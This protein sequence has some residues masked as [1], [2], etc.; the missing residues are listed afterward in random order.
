MRRMFMICVAAIVSAAISAQ[1]NDLYSS[2][3][4]T[5]APTPVT[6][7]QTQT[8]SAAAVSANPT[9][10][11]TVSY[12]TSERDVD[13]YNRRY[14][15]STSTS[16]DENVSAAGKVVHDTVYLK[17]GSYAQGYNDAS[18]EY[19]YALRMMRFHSVS[20]SLLLSPFYWDVVYDPW[21]RYPW[22]GVWVYDPW[23]YPV[24]NP[25]YVGPV[26]VGPAYIAPGVYVRRDTYIPDRRINAGWDRKL[27][28]GAQRDGR[29]GLAASDSR[30]A[31]NTGSGRVS[32]AVTQPIS[33]PAEGTRVE[34]QVSG[35]A[36]PARSNSAYAQRERISSN[37]TAVRSENRKVADSSPRN[38]NATSSRSTNS[39]SNTY[40]HPSS[41]ARSSSAAS[42]S[43]TREVRS[44]G[45]SPVSSFGGAGGSRGGSS[46]GGGSMGGGSSMGGASMGGGARGSSGFSGRR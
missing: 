26:Y 18:E 46:F 37:A 7:V 25:V 6:E 16:S 30:L 33:R 38:L 14:A 5:V 23:Y 32:S 11:E 31:G 12:T 27:A 1:R 17:S 20:V 9:V 21:Y 10:A 34:R 4:K 13:E 39:S 42:S 36:S 2:S 40:S 35:T 22:R 44:I 41:T 45:S 43:Q 24:Y 28:G 15:Y 3:A 29:Y 8:V 19:E